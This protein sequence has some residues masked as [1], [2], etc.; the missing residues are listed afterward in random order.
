M[1]LEEKLKELEKEGI[2]ID[3]SISW[4]KYYNAVVKKVY[5]DLVEFE[6]SGKSV[7]VRTSWITAIYIPKQKKEKS[8]AR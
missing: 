2:V 5:S 7:F 3:F 1:T 4:N 8:G 6:Q